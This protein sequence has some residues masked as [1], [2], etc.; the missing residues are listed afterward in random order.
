MGT[1]SSNEYS[2]KP[3][4]SA[5]KSVADAIKIGSKRAIQKRGEV[6]GNLIG[7]KIIERITSASKSSK[8]LHLQNDLDEADIPKERFI[9]WEKRQQIT[10]ESRLV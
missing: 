10:N 3:F 7:N 6:T 5:K 9:T 2:Q 4:D 8:K 1:H